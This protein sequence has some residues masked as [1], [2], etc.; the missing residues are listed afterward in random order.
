MMI[1]R[2][3]RLARYCFCEVVDVNVTVAGRRRLG[4]PV[5]KA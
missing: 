2:E 1:G 4:V 5:L 3:R